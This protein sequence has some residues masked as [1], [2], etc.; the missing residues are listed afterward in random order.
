MSLQRS[1]FLREECAQICCSCTKSGPLI[2]YTL[3]L[4]L[5]PKPFLG[6]LMFMLIRANRQHDADID[7]RGSH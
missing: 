2:C 1:F 5:L 4:Y 6:G 7:H 3:T